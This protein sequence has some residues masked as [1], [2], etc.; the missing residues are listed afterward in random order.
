[1]D[2]KSKIKISISITENTERLLQE[3]GKRL[4]NGVQLSRGDVVDFLA[5]EKAQALG[6]G[7]G[8]LTDADALLEKWEKDISSAQ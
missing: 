2:N 7:R 1:M 4:V 5:A 3:M 8:A 6:L